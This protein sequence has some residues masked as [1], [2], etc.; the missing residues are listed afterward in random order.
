MCVFVLN[1]TNG[2]CLNKIKRKEIS[3]RRL[4]PIHFSSSSSSSCFCRWGV[5]LVIISNHFVKFL[6]L[7]TKYLRCWRLSWLSCEFMSAR[8]SVRVC[9]GVLNSKRL[10]LAQLHVP[11]SFF[12]C[13]FYISCRCSFCSNQIYNFSLLLLLSPLLLLT[14]LDFVILLF[15]ERLQL[16][17]IFLSLTHIMPFFISFWMHEKV[18][19]HSKANANWNL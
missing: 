17:V 8:A 5:M 1:Y 18:H 16:Q 9:L 11:N 7:Y 19:I 15:G 10:I 14:S 6:H 12:F 4:K 13:F 3:R 2:F